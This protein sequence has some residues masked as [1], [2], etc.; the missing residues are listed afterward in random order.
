MKEPL[1]ETCEFFSDAQIWPHE[2]QVD[3]A[4]WL[5]NFKADEL[6]YA[7]DLLAA[8][9]LFNEKICKAILRSTLQKVSHDIFPQFTSSRQA[10]WEDLLNKAI[11]TTV[12][13]QEGN[14]TASGNLICRWGKQYL[15]I[16]EERILNNQ[17]ALIAL[18]EGKANTVFFL[19]DF[20]GSG[21]Q[22]TDS[23]TTLH[24]IGKKQISFPFLCRS[25]GIKAYYLPLIATEYGI[26]EIYKTCT[27]IIIFPG[28]KLDA[29]YSATHK[30]SI[31]WSDANR[32]GA[33]DFLNTVSKRAG[34]ENEILG[35]QSLALTIAFSHKIPDATLPIFNWNQNGWKPL[36]ELS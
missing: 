21:I 32:A 24:H 9:C 35:F 33:F 11:Y 6:P 13:I 2:P 10:D 29:K 31:I 26:S 17:Q 1:I 30:D 20:V 14:I 18:D 4:G 8:F 34:I 3:Y 36:M 12:D 23:W 16:P 15:K 27:D 19:D 7:Y 25:R 5:N 28:N 22:F